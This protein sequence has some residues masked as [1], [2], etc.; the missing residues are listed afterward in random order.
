MLHI[1]WMDKRF[2]RFLN[3]E[4]HG[5]RLASAFQPRQGSRVRAIDDRM[6]L[7]VQH[8]HID[9]HQLWPLH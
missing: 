3:A 5:S 4:D 9:N 2:P 8:G 1:L 6:T 7:M